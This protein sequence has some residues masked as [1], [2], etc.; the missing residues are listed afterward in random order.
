MIVFRGWG[1]I[2]FFLGIGCFVAGLLGV[3]ALEPGASGHTGAQSTT[4]GWRAVALGLLLETPEVLAACSGRAS[5]RRIHRV[6]LRR[7]PARVV[8]AHLARKRTS[9]AGRLG[10]GADA[11]GPK[12]LGSLG[13]LPDDG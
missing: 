9:A 1:W 2:V 11:R 10:W 8:I 5:D 6:I 13:S 3:Y 7:R 4:D 12:P